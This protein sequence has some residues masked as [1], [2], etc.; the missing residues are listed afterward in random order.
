MKPPLT[1]HEAENRCSI[2]KSQK[3][4]I[5]ELKKQY[6]ARIIDVVPAPLPDDNYNEDYVIAKY[7]GD[8]EAGESFEDI[9]RRLSFNNYDTLIIYRQY[10]HTPIHWV[11]LATTFSSLV[12]DGVK[13]TQHIPPAI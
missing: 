13:T 5:K 6:G 4:I 9:A 12:E 3:W 7:L 2:I 8:H 10:K 11:W 1:F